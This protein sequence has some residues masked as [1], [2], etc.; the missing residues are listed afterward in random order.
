MLSEEKIADYIE[1]SSKD[2][3]CAIDSLLINQDKIYF[4]NHSFEADIKKDYRFEWTK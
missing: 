3:R 2:F 1:N 4:H